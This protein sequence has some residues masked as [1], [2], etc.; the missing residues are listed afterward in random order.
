[1]YEGSRGCLTTADKWEVIGC[2]WRPKGS[3]N[4][5]LQAT[6]NNVRTADGMVSAK[7][8][9]YTYQKVFN[10]GTNIAAGYIQLEPGAKN[11]KRT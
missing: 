6:E 2:L 4:A 8:A 10:K 3:E 7:E 9:D 11:P 1:M 5:K